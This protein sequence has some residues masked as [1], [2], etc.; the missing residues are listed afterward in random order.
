M[1]F[2]KQ[3]F[4]KNIDNTLHRKFTRFSLG[5][6]ERALI[7]IKTSKN[8]FRIKTSADFAND[9]VKLISENIKESS[10]VS[11][12]LI[13]PRDFEQDLDIEINKYSKRGKL[14]TA[15]I[16]TILTPEQLKN[17]YNLFKDDFLLLSIKSKDFK[18]STGKALPRPGGKLKDNFCKATLPINLLKEF[19]FDIK[20]FKEVEIKHIYKITDIEIPEEYKNDFEQARIHAKRKGTLI[21]ILNIDGKEEKKEIDFSI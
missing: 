5:E 18:L 2:I 3:I 20:N 16:K 13:A 15:E 11:G 10:E 19:T 6:Y 1:S 17:I 7:Q 21:R 4:E 9:F 8:S 14:Y 12:K